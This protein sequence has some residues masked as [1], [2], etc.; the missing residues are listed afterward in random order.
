MEKIG[1]IPV[2]LFVFKR[3]DT[4]DAIVERIK[5]YAPQRVYLIADGPRNLEEER[6]VS[7]CRQHVEKLID[8][9]CE[10]IKNYSDKN[11]G[12]YKN[13]GEGALW[14]FEREEKAIFLEDDN[15]PESSFFW[16]CESMLDRY[17]KAERVL[18]IMGSNYLGKAIFENNAS[19]S[20]TRHML[21]CG[22]ASW[23][24]K[25]SKYYDGLFNKKDALSSFDKARINYY[26][27]Q[28]YKYDRSR[29]ETEYYRITKGM[30]PISWDYQ[31]AY[32][33]RENNLV[34]IIPKFNQITNIG[35][36][37]YSIHGGN[38]KTNVMV[39]R[40]CENPSYLLEEEI[41]HPQTIGTGE[42][43]EKALNKIILPPLRMRLKSSIKTILVKC[44]CL[45]P[46]KSISKE[47]LRKK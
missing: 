15:L 35:V 41:I 25:F 34:G 18:W 17:E 12:V 5:T 1:K 9:P 2:V 46:N 3:K 26:S 24:S 22:W 23:A 7:S 29:W 45:N 20:F 11:R 32:T 47:I 6:L 33:I 27:S 38:K 28:F 42:R 14:V 37:D 44:F 10:I 8:W 31:M 43:F 40:F 4:L 19:Y 30:N 36:D 16:F 13:I 21:P 39:D